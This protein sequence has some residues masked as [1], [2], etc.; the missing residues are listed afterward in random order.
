MNTHREYRFP[1]GRYP[2]VRVS[3]LFAAGI[4]IAS[5]TDAG[6]YL[7]LLLFL[8]LF[9]LWIFSEYLEKQ[10]GDAVSAGAAVFILLCMVPALGGL[11]FSFT[12]EKQEHIRES[13]QHLLLY[14]W[15]EGI[16]IEGRVVSR[17]L[18]SAGRYNYD[19][20]VSWTIVE[21]SAWIFPYTIRLYGE[22]AAGGA[23][24]YVVNDYR[25]QAAG[26]R[27][28]LG[29]RE[30]G[31][32]DRKF[33]SN[34]HGRRTTILR[35]G[36]RIKAEIRIFELEKSGN[37]GEFDYRTFLHRQGIFLHGE[38]VESVVTERDRR[39]ELWNRLRQGVHHRIEELFD[40]E[41]TPLA[42]ALLTGYR[43]EL[44]PEERERFARAGISHIMAV[45]G[46]HVGFIVAPFWLLIPWLWQWRFGGWIGLILL[47]VVL[48][49]FAG[50]A[51]FS[52]SVS[53]ASLMAWLLSAGKLMKRM[54]ESINLM[55][56]SALVLLLVDPRQLFE[57]GFQ[58]S[59]GAVF[60]I[61]L[62]LPH[63]NELVP[64]QFRES[65][66]GKLVTVIAISVVVQFGLY[67][68]LIWYFGEFSLIGPVT[69]ALVV[70]L[71]SFVVPATFLLIFLVD[72][73]PDFAG[74]LNRPG[75]LVFRWI[76]WL[77]ERLGGWEGSWIASE[78]HSALIFLTW[79]SLTGFL[80]SLR[81]PSLRNLFLKLLMVSLIWVQLQKLV[82]TLKPA[83]L[84]IVVLDV[85]QGDAIHLS[86]PN[87]KEVLIDTGRWSPFGNSGEQ[88]LL[89]YLEY[90]GI[91][92]LDAVIL[93]HPHSDHIG[94][95]PALLQQVEI[96][97][98]YHAG[99]DYDS[100]LFHR[101]RDLAAQKGIGKRAVKKGDILKL[102]RSVRFFVLGP[103]GRRHNSNPNDHS[104]VIRLVYNQTSI[105]FTGDAEQ[106]QESRVIRRYGDFLRADLLKVGHHGS[107]TSSSRPFLELSNPQMAAV[108]L[109]FRNRY[110]HPHPD[111]VR[112][113]EEVVGRKN[114]HY[115]SLEGAIW[116]RSDG[117]KILRYR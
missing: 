83:E 101:I 19:V 56:F 11:Y 98:I 6:I 91:E 55:G 87:G 84:E 24:E 22:Q 104:V 42:K 46:L 114:I 100:Q 13:A 18:S 107:N 96:D 117:Q 20:A 23:G 15:E 105:L 116:Y 4:I 62:L 34:D 12:H 67:P 61:L 73:F 106:Y 33:D 8:L 58:L 82:S 77:A 90:R 111:A 71:L 35:A 72:F 53:R 44:G 43:Q 3:L 81:L 41:S 63:F 5:A 45:S 51:G 64:H 80:A 52:P 29:I 28:D 68:V 74:M 108:S 49:A 16:E 38:L 65:A 94:G 57:I 115:T 1:F 102:D 97:S 79:A 40:S 92:R 26:E 76:A 2:G 110:R 109:A 60:V 39:K 66:A 86:T 112:R 47:T 10:Y 7:F 25:E 88:V 89:P 113:L 14:A 95:M 31:D 70:P 75:H 50:L 37:P 78:G 59:Y 48:I 103:D 27:G 85:G 99:F 93:S 54:T 69:N 36:D 9:T 21:G 17:N 32:G 30:K